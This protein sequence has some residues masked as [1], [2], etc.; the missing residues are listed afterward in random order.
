MAKNSIDKETLQKHSFWIVLGVFA[1]LWLVAVVM[2]KVTAS[3]TAKKKWD[4]TKKSIEG[5][6]SQ[7]PKN[8]KFLEPWNKHGEQFRNHKDKIWAKAWKQQEN[9]YDWPENMPREAQP[10]YFDDPFARTSAGTVDT[11]RDL[12]NRNKFTT[13]WYPVQF[14]GLDQY[15]FPAQFNGGFFAV[16]PAQQWNKSMAPTREEIWL[17]QEDFWVRREM[18][19]MIREALNS[20]ALLREVPPEKGKEK[21]KLPDGILG[22]KVFRN[23]NWE[24]TLLFER[25][26]D[27]RLLAISAESTI[28]NVS[29]D[30]RTLTLAHPK[31]KGG[32]PFRLVQGNAISEIAVAGEPLAHKE[33]SKFGKSY[34]TSPVDVS[35]PFE[36]IQVLEW[37]ISPIRRIDALELARHSHRTF[38]G[39]L[40]VHEELKKLD[41]DPEGSVDTAS[42][43]EGASGTGGTGGTGGTSSLGT[44]PTPG[45]PG[46]PGGG[47]SEAMS[48]GPGGLG[49][50]GA[51]TDGTK[52]NMIDRQRYLHV[53]PQCRHLPVAMRLVIEQSHI[54]DLLTAV[55]NSRLRIQVTQVTLHHSRDVRAGGP[56]TTGPGSTRPG[57]PGGPGTP[58]GTT[59]PGGMYGAG[60][61]MTGMRPGGISGLPGGRSFM[62]G[63]GG[64]GG[65]TDG[66]IGSGGITGTGTPGTTEGT[67]TFQDNARLVELTIYGIASLYERFPPKPPKPAEAQPAPTT[68]TK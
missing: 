3:E 15:V 46:G 26:K 51:P 12:N 66:I 27:S 39:G 68:P 38:T 21:E 36:V 41:P 24:L 8:E 57:M 52:V 10:K 44:T 62:P 54:H 19:I 48:G 53:T 34:T 35:K 32:L 5:A 67:P 1:L 56:T 6:M 63:V 65:G 37:E 17:A 61:A 22:K 31:N 28:K 60:A 18:L 29:Q 55:A 4:D 49:G 40:K 30:E 50:G 23:S 25:G 33:S 43:T 2:V 11:S 64:V 16:F 13:D 59:G 9:M 20:M 47:R 7:G 42:T 58:G 45:A 14:V